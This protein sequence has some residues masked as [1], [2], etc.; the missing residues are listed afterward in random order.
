VA[1]DHDNNVIVTGQSSSGTDDDFAT[2][3]YSIVQPIPLEIQL[4][5]SQLVLT[6]ANP[7]FS[8]QSAPAITGAFTNMPGATSPHTN[9]VSGSQQFFRLISN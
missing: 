6:W 9:P 7:A 2:I 5:E 4:V 1:V 3:K 8:L